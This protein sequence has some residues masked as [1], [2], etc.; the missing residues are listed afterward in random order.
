MNVSRDKTTVFILGGLG[1]A[2]ALAVWAAW[3][4]TAV[5]DIR[6][7]IPREIKRR[8]QAEKLRAE[9]KRMQQQVRPPSGPGTA[10]IQYL[11]QIA[12]AHG[13]AS[14][15]GINEMPAGRQDPK[16]PY[17]EAVYRV[18]LADVRRESFVKFLV[19]AEANRPSLRTKEIA[20]QKF[21][22]EGDILLASVQFAY[23]EKKKP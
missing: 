3:A 13:I 10:N 22:P 12:N 23:Y 11:T 1:L 17:T 14:L 6:D 19:D 4:Y 2:A 5:E 21:S 18:D 20:I 9:V 16:I 7:R 15:K 8:A